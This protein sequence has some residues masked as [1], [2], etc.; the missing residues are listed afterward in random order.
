[1]SRILLK[2]N[3]ISPLPLEKSPV[4]DPV[5]VPKEWKVR[6]H[7]SYSC[8]WFLL[9]IAKYMYAILLYAFLHIHNWLILPIKSLHLPSFTGNVVKH[10]KYFQWWILRTY[11]YKFKQ[12]KYFLTCIWNASTTGSLWISQL[13]RPLSTCT[14]RTCINCNYMYMLF[15]E[16]RLHSVSLFTFILHGKT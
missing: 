7:W 14:V 15:L 5:H 8:V 9:C 6:H 12:T 11:M 2:S 1:M 10:V 16:F 4:W 3:V 13:H